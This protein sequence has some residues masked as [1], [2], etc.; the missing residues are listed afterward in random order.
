[1]PGLK[2]VIGAGKPPAAEDDEMT[3]FMAAVEKIR[4]NLD[5]LV[6]AYEADR[7]GKMGLPDLEDSAEDEMGIGEGKA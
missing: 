3:G 2:V 4:G 6:A 1:M 5:E 7:A